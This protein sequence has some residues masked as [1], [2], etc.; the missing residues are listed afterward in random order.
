MH[1]FNATLTIAYSLSGGMM[2][3]G[4]IP[5]IW[6]LIIS[7][8]RS[9]AISIPTYL[10]WF[11]CTFISGLYAMFVAGDMLISL[12]GFAASFGNFTIISLTLYN[13][14]WRFKGQPYVAS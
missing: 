4:F 6:N 13:R 2:L 7:T 10:I 12:I 1:D 8:G 11:I 14:Y 5:Q 3:A 9:K